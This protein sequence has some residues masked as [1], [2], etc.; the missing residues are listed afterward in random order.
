MFHRQ[1]DAV[2]IG[3]SAG[4]IEALSGILTKLPEGF[5]IPILIVVH[6]PM[7]R[8]NAIVDLFRRK[9]QI[10]VW[11]AEDKGPIRAGKIY[12]APPDYHLLIEQDASFSLSTEPLVNFSR[13]SIDV[14]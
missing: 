1:I 5:S 2:V 4:A 13:P 8:D 12:F 3:A 10:P 9:C 7:D 14:L 11:E 6:L